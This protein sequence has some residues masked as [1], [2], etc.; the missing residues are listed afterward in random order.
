MIEC[1]R[2]NERNIRS[3]LSRAQRRRRAGEIFF[4]F[5]SPPCFST[6]MYF[7]INARVRRSFSGSPAGAENRVVGVYGTRLTLKPGGCSSQRKAATHQLTQLFA[8]VISMWLFCR[9]ADLTNRSVRQDCQVPVSLSFSLSFP[10]RHAMTELRLPGPSRG[11]RL[12]FTRFRSSY[13]P[14]AV[15][16]ADR[17]R[18]ARLA[19][20]S[21]AFAWNAAFR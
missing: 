3:Q 19:I 1:R 10:R 2:L 20:E 15:T 6:R 18:S 5:F 17:N 14:K 4:P 12:G 21:E 8:P 13:A 7:S 9:S 16:L 11:P